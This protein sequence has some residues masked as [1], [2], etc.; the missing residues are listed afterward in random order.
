MAIVAGAAAGG[1][2]GTAGSAAGAAAVGIAEEPWGCISILAAPNPTLPIAPTP[3]QAAVLNP[4]N[5]PAAA[6]DISFTRNVYVINACARHQLIGFIGKF[7]LSLFNRFSGAREHHRHVCIGM[8]QER[9]FA[10]RTGCQ[11]IITR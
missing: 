10:F 1:T 4:K 8:R 6:P 2:A 5:V 7:V 11:N 3:A 9:L